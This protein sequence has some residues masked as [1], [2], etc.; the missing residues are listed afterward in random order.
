MTHAAEL[1]VGQHAAF[2]P[3]LPV[4]AGRGAAPLIISVPPAAVDGDT[5]TRELEAG[6]ST[7]SSSTVAVQSSDSHTPALPV[8]AGP[9]AAPLIVS[10]PPAAVDGDAYTR[11]LEAGTSQT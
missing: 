2:R 5:Y 10:V 8:S 4:S 3:A 7:G 6:T 1:F 11:E 9:G